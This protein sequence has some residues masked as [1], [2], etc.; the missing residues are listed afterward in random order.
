V[1]GHKDREV[2][3]MQSAETVLGVLREREVLT[4]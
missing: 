1:I 4:Q 2:C 3:E